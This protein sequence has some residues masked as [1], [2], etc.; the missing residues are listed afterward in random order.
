MRELRKS[1]DIPVNQIIQMVKQTGADISD[2][3]IRRFFNDDVDPATNWRQGNFEAISDVLL[4]TNLTDFDPTKGQMYYQECKELK[5]MLRDCER[6]ISALEDKIEA[7]NNTVA[8]SEKIVNFLM[9]EVVF[10]R[11]R[12]EYIS[13]DKQKKE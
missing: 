2:S 9:D 13:P 4:G 3:M 11:K 7:Y 8:R 1:Q 10:L 6:M 5:M 12:L